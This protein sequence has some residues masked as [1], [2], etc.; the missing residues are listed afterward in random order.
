MRKGTYYIENTD[1]LNK[2]LALLAITIPCFIEK[3][4]IE[5]NYSEVTITAR[6]ED[7]SMVEK[8]LAPLV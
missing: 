6:I 7:F 8:F 3:D 4:G 5:M 2:T 1:K